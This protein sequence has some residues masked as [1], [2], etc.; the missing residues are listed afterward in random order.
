MRI[1]NAK[2]AFIKHIVCRILRCNVAIQFCVQ[3]LRK[4]LLI[5]T[6]KFTIFTISLSLCYNPYK[7]LQRRSMSRIIP[8]MSRNPFGTQ[9]L[10]T[11]LEPKFYK[12]CCR[13]FSKS[14]K[15]NCILFKYSCV[16]KSF[17]NLTV[18]IKRQC[19]DKWLTT[20]SKHFNSNKF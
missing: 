2:L 17:F 3:A 13:L 11:H 10:E 14:F 20:V 6:H 4:I 18:L 15:Y 16:I 7:P 1:S 9:K 12:Y 19:I 8:L 5:Y